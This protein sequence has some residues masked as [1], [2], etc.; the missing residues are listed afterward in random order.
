MTGAPRDEQD[1]EELSYDDGSRVIIG[2]A[3]GD[4]IVVE[5]ALRPRTLESFIGQQRVKDQLGLVLEAA[6]AR[7]SSADHVLLAGPPGLG[8]TTLSMIIAAELGMPLRVTSGP[9]L[10]HAG[11]LAA[12]LSSLVPGEVL[13]LDEIHRMSRAAEEMLYLAME[14]FRVDIIVGKGP[15]ATAIPLELPAF[16]LVGATT[17]AG[18]LPGPLRDRFGFTAHMDFYDTADLLAIAVRSARLLEVS[19]TADAAAEIAS[20]SR[21]TPRVANRLLRRVR[22]FAQVRADGNIDLAITRAA[23]ALYEVDDIGL[24]RLD[25]AVLDSLLRRFGG[26]PVGLSTLAV[27]VGEEPETVETVCEP[28]LVRAGLLART[29]RGR[30]ATPAAWRHLGLRP[31]AHSAGLTLFAGAPEQGDTFALDNSPWADLD[32]PPEVVGEAGHGAEVRA[33]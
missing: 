20:R 25:R 6:S 28:F 10:Q 5:G 33:L 13:F 12:V 18:L 9:A 26:G 31:P 14:D 19:L 27:S 30:V 1:S 22:D 7:G 17:R 4:D 29:P 8:K 21:G 3:V 23:L 2:E 11:D 32:N 16:T 24:D 15:G